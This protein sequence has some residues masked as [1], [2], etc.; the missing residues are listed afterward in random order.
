MADYT[1]DRT[2]ASI[3]LVLDNA[4]ALHAAG[5]DDY[6]EGTW[7]PTV[8][9]GTVSPSASSV[10]IKVGNKVT[11]WG[12]IDTF[13]DRTTSSGVSVGGLPFVVHASYSDH[14]VGSAMGRYMDIQASTTY[15]T[16][17]S[18][19]EFFSVSSTDFQPLNHNNLN[20]AAARIYFTATYF[21][22]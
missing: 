6:E 17:T 4:D 16:G 3:D 14:A 8:A 10:Y 1:S 13:S 20:N 18:R 11:I 9:I 2:G 7:T 12:Q 15:I 5:L 19:I 22:V 21:T